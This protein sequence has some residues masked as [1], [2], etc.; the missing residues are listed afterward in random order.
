MEEGGEEEEELTLITV[1]LLSSISAL[2]G[3]SFLR[4]ST[5]LVAV[6]AAEHLL[7]FVEKSVHYE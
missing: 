2:L 3:I 7:S 5:T 4:G 1:I 6:I